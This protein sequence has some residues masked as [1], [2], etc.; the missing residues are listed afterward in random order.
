[1]FEFSRRIWLVV[2]VKQGR[3]SDFSFCFV[4][5]SS[6]PVFI[7]T[8]FPIYIFRYNRKNYLYIVGF[9]LKFLSTLYLIKSLIYAL[10]Y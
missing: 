1:M 5:S 8:N 9:N 3:Q 4:N 10:I 7:L 2:R 6:M